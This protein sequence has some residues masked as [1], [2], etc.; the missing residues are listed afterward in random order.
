LDPAN[1]TDLG[2]TITATNST[3]TISEGISTNSQ[4]FYR[5]VLLP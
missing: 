3:M 4:Q 2:G 1:W 5:V